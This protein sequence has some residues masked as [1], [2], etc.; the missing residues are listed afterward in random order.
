MDTLEKGIIETELP[1]NKLVELTTDYAP[2]MCGKKSGLAAKVQEKMK[3]R[4]G[5]LIASHCIIHQEALC[6]KM[7]GMEHLMYKNTEF[8]LSMEL[9]PLPV[10][11]T[12]GGRKF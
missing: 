10:Q 3:D 4:G 8:H 12:F 11:G 5:E 1:W 7:P 2:A 9:E 6:G